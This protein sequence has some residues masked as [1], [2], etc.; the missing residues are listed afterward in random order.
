MFGAL[1]AFAKSGDP[2][3]DGLPAWPR[4][5]ARE[6][7]TMLFNGSPHVRVNFDRELL[8][9]FQEIAKKEEE[10]ARAEAD[11]RH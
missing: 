2:N 1:I 4:C 8:D 11:I 9:A 3:H 5:D 6:E 7:R 10:R